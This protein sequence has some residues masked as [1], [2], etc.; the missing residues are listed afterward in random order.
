MNK[1]ITHPSHF[2]TTSNLLQKGK[3]IFPRDGNKSLHLREKR[4][5][6]FPKLSLRLELIKKK[7]PFNLFSP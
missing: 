2:T 6:L 5:F 7:W 4:H 3:Y 1:S